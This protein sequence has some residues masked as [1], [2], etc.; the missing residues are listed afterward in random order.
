MKRLFIA[1]PI[2]NESK[3][4]IVSGILSDE[5][6]KRMPVRWSAYQN[7]HLTL[8]FLGDV[9]EKRVGD[10]KQ[11]LNR[12]RVPASKEYLKFS[13]L[14]SHHNY[15]NLDILLENSDKPNLN[16][17]FVSLFRDW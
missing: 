10:L 3:T 12:I 4:K 11:I 15:H 5:K 2:Q 14:L 9:D 6:I 1:I 13:K 8:Q 16:L 17:H 7:L